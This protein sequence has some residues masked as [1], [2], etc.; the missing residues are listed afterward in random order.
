MY[1]ARKGGLVD[2]VYTALGHCGC[3]SCL[4]L[5][6]NI[7]AFDFVIPICRPRSIA[8]CLCGVCIIIFVVRSLANR[9]TLFC[10]LKKKV[11]NNDDCVHIESRE[12]S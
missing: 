1:D 11:I 9:Y 2:F 3:R 5:V 6:R 10:V 7:S 8:L 4:A 12:L